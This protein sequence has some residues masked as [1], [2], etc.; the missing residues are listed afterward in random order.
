MN[1]LIRACV[2]VM[3]W[4]AAAAAQVVPGRYVVELLE[5]PL[6]AAVRTAG[7]SAL[8]N[9]HRTI[10]SEQAQA[11]TLIEQRTGRV[12]SSVDS[13]MN[14][15]IVRIPDEQAATLATLPGVKQVYPV[16]EVKMHLDHALPLHQ[17]PAAWTRIGG[18]DNAGAGIKIAILD[19]GISPAHPAFQDPAL[20]VPPGYPKASKQENLAVTNNKIIVA[21]SYEDI[22]ETKEP[23]DARDRNGHGTAT[24][25]CAAGVTNRGTFAT[26]T[27][28]APKAWIGGYKIVQLNTGSASGDVILKAM[29]DALADGMDVINLSFGSPF[30]FSEGP[31]LLPAVALDRLARFGVIIVVSAGNSGPG[32]NTLGN[33]AASPAVIAVGATE[34]D[35]RLNGSISVAGRAPY[36]AFP[37]VGQDST[38]PIS[39][40]ILD[41]ASLDPAGLGCA[42]FPA[43]SAT[44]KILLILRGVCT[45]EQKLLNAEAGGAIAAIIYT[46]AAR[47]DAFSPVVAT[48]KLP[49]VLV[50]FANGTAIKAA[51]AA[52][53]STTAAIVFGGVPYPADPHRVASFTSKGPTWNFR[54]K[55]DLTAVGT[56]VYT[57]TQSLD[58]KGEIYAK[59]GYALLDGT[60][61]SSPIVAGAAAVLRAARP[62]LTV[63]QYRSLLINSASP[64]TR[65][66]GSVEGVQRTGVGVLNLDV[67]LQNTVTAF[68]TSL[69]FGVGNGTL[70]G[71]ATG[72]LDQFALTNIG[73]TSDTYRISA[74]PY[75]F[76]PALQFSAAPRDRAPN[77]T[78]S[79]TIAPGQT[80]TIYAY[81]TAT[82]EPGEYQGQIVIEGT[83][84]AGLIPYWYAAPSRNPRSI[85]ELTTLPD[86]ARVGTGVTLFVRVTDETGF[87]LT[88][89]AS[90]AFQG[91]VTA[92][93]GSIAL[94]TGTF[95]P[96]LRGVLLTLGPNAGNNV[97]QFRFGNLPP[98]TH[99]ITGTPAPTP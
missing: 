78:Y 14:A 5:E 54:I 58:E 75:D 4:A 7:K 2:G 41:A 21:R 67:A 77:S 20:K 55:P 47:P 66:D 76:A 13:L 62:G 35:R 22:Y 6:G 81:W 85:F 93:G 52:N 69:T 89:D 53:S 24:A 68:P 3:L 46:D 96:N 33:Y 8:G 99:A 86:S 25:M 83:Q 12:L 82:L 39:A 34:N 87:P 40:T 38:V 36:E 19:T 37:G 71:A 88:D 95:F 48:A 32:L 64:L 31:D 23:D 45:F 30:T 70:G 26:I 98:V 94:R 44:G 92:G 18:K 57:A 17:V 10:L 1:P 43:A 9:R 90:L 61:F 49:A 97:F 59:D 91:S 74:I 11:R 63:E 80:K 60:S 56:S 15:L 42:P 72:D 79:L 16:Y 51:V 73:K 65:I 28:V 27:G 29:D 84:G 50:S